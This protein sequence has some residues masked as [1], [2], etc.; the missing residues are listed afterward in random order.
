MDIYDYDE[1][2]RVH[3]V[4]AGLDE[5]GRGPIA[6]PVVAAA[7]VLPAHLRIEGLRDSKKLTERQRRSLYY[8]ILCLASDI[9]VG[10]SEVETI[11]RVNILESTRLAM[12]LAVTDLHKE[13]HMLL[14]DAVNLPELGIRQLS[15]YKGESLS[16]SIAAASIVAKVVRDGIMEQ[17]HGVYPAYGFDRHKG[18]STRVHLE[19]LRAHGPCPIHRRSFGEV[20]SPLLPF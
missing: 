16:A 6:G 13:P 12:A 15:P 10:V 3:G 2:F 4:V 7:V 1:S 9:G 18:Y 19:A 11:D 8:D 20:L 5:A 14:I 17:Y